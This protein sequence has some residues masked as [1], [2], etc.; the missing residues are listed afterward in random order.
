MVSHA[1]AP[2]RIDVCDVSVSFPLYHGNSRSLKKTVI[3][4]ASG[5]LR[6]DR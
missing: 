4:A 3:A 5:R 6:Q 2:A 1:G